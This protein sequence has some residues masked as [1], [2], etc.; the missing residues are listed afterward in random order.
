MLRRISHVH[1]TP[2]ALLLVMSGPQSDTA[3]NTERQ[4]VIL[5]AICG[6]KQPP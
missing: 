3:Q 4:S 5:S 1:H 6:A 2:L